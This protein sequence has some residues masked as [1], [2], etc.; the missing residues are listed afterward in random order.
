MYRLQLAENNAW[1]RFGALTTSHTA[2]LPHVQGREDF[3]E[4]RSSSAVS[5]SYVLKEM[6]WFRQKNDG[7][8]FSYRVI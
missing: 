6:I 7:E 5:C 8:S 1:K 3:M 4:E 2:K